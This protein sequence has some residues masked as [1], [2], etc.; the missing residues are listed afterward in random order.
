M[1]Q[2]HSSGRRRSSTKSVLRLPDLEQRQDRSVEQRAL[3]DAII[4]PDQKSGGAV[5]AGA[6]EFIDLLSSEQVHR[7]RILHQRNRNQIPRLHR[8]H[9][10]EGVS[11][12]PRDT[13]SLES[14]DLGPRIRPRPFRASIPPEDGWI[15]R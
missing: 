7:R 15:I 6:P 1:K 9:L 8:Q 12:L 3:C 4:P 11:G 2:K 14:A 13:G 10:P 5:E